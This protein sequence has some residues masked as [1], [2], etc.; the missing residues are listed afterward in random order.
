MYLLKS[1]FRAEI[2]TRLILALFNVATE[3]AEY[4]HLSGKPGVIIAILVIYE[5]MSSE[6]KVSISFTL[7]RF[8]NE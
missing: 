8:G 7:I 1:L 3:S 6:F 4:A 2:S 5:C